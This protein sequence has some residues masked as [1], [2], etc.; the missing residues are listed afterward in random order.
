MRDRGARGKRWE[1]EGEV[2][3]KRVG[4]GEVGEVRCYY[5]RRG[6]GKREWMDRRGRVGGW[7][8]R[9]VSR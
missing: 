5:G 9:Y 7:V 6:E 2:E 8:G 4:R 1:G 3:G